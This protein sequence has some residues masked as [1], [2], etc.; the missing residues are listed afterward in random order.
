MNTALDEHEYGFFSNHWMLKMALCYVPRPQ[1]NLAIAAVIDAI[2][3]QTEDNQIS[4]RD[5]LQLLTQIGLTGQYRSVAPSTP[6]ESVGL[7]VESFVRGL[8]EMPEAVDPMVDFKLN[9]KT[10]EENNDQ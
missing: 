9:N 3:S 4:G 6:P 5:L 7:D 10:E 1:L 8:Q 2:T